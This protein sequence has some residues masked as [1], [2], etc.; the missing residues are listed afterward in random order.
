MN[1]LKEFDVIFY[2]TNGDIFKMLYKSET[3]QEVIDFFSE[4]IG[5]CDYMSNTAEDAFIKT[6]NINYFEIKEKEE[7]AG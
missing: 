7:V 4:K 6:E 3:M 2:M 5:R 1:N